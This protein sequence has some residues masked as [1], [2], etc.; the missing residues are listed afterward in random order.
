MATLHD[1]QKDYINR[2]KKNAEQHFKDGDYDWVASLVEKSGAQRILEIGCGVGYSTLAP[3]RTF[4]PVAPGGTW[5]PW[6]YAQ[7]APFGNTGI[8][9]ILRNE[10]PR[11]Q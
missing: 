4:H 1:A 6:G 5:L 10:R 2:W 3:C 9:E 8:F 11:V 7:P